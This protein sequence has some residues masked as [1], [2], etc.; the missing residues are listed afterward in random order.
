MGGM[1]GGVCA[2]SSGIPN[3][4]DPITLS[5][6]KLKIH[7]TFFREAV[8]VGRGLDGLNFRVTICQLISV[9]HLLD[10]EKKHPEIE[11]CMP[12]CWGRGTENWNPRNL[13]T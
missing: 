11:L 3:T 5:S 9:D 6:C 4:P 8:P 2:S 13:F 1:S 7:F 12:T 10:S